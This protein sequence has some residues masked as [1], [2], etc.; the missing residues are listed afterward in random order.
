MFVM[1][2]APGAEIV[3]DG[4]RYLYFAGTGYLGL[5]GHAEVI[6]A[7]CEATRR[8]GIGSAT[9]RTGFGNTPPTLEVE[10]Q[11]A[12]FFGMDES[13]YFVSGYVSN[14]VLLSALEGAFDAVFVDERSHY[15]VFEAARACARPVFNFRHRDPEDL[16]HGLRRH[17]KPG[18]RPVVL[19]DGVFAGMGRIAPVAE[20]RKVLASYPGAILAVDDA[21]GIGVLGA[22]G[23]GT[24][25]HAGL[26]GGNDNNDGGAVNAVHPLGPCAS[27][28]PGVFFCGTLSK[29]IGG[30]GGILPGSQSFIEGVKKTSRYY[31]GASAPPIPAAAATAKALEIVR[32]DPGLRRRLWENVGQVKSGLRRHGLSVDDTPVPILGLEIG[33]GANMQR[34]QESLKER[35]ILIAYMAAYSGLGPEGALRLAVFA[36]HTDAMIRR[37]LEELARVL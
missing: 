7:A 19:T 4:R 13:F 26:M 15:C 18:E 12:R 14:H 8:Y 16:E 32:A 34:L 11:A 17:L 33:T 35:G 10:R 2:S 3:L 21:H 28:G 31:S 20:Y 30:F 36:T 37:L 23:R 1:E 9:S 25:E 6:R 5:Q 27:S 24:L 29:A 22:S